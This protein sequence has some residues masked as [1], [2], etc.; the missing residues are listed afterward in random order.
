MH[1]KRNCCQ[2]KGKVLDN[3]NCYL[4]QFHA[5]RSSRIDYRNSPVGYQKHVCTFSY[6]VRGQTA[7][8]LETV[9]LF[10]CV[11]ELR[12]REQY[13]EVTYFLQ[14]CVSLFHSP[15]NCMPVTNCKSVAITFC[16]F[17]ATIT[18]QLNLL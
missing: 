4:T 15:E 12:E 9:S 10:T 8:I 14:L 7:F 18:Q 1:N 3:I 16:L 5:R 17:R 6:Q 11:S 2:Q 13:D